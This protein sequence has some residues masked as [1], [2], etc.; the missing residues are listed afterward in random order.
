[1]KKTREIMVGTDL[2]TIN[3]HDWDIVKILTRS[4]IVEKEIVTTECWFYGVDSNHYELTGEE[5]SFRNSKRL[6][7]M[8][9]WDTIGDLYVAQDVNITELDGYGFREEF[10]QNS[11]DTYS[12]L[13]YEDIDKYFD[14]AYNAKFKFFST[15]VDN[16]IYIELGGFYNR[17][18]KDHKISISKYLSYLVEKF[19]MDDM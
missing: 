4:G 8:N 18:K 1:M 19:I 17:M 9:S 12:V 10:K 15:D 6:D 3:P 14:G 5:E 16:F 2:V 7:E 11:D 13:T